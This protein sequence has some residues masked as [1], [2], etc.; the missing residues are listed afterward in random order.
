MTD[1]ELTDRKHKALYAM[2]LASL[3]LERQPVT[4]EELVDFGGEIDDVTLLKSKEDAAALLSE[5]RD[6]GLVEKY[7]QVGR[8]YRNVLTD[9]GIELLVE[10][11]APDGVD[12]TVDV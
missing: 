3:R 9:E 1:S 12:E 8:S 7:D 5:F 10:A 2:Y 6:M 11:G 4:T